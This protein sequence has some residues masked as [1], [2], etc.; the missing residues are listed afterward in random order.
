MHLYVIC[1]LAG[2]ELGQMELLQIMCKYL[3]EEYNLRDCLLST[4]ES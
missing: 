2:A 3:K 1:D 4:R